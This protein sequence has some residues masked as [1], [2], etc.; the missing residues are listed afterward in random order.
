MQSITYVAVFDIV[1]KIRKMEQN[2]QFF[3]IF[4]EVFRPCP[5]NALVPHLNLLSNERSHEDTQS[6]QVSSS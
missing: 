6:C 1:L 3:G 5:P 4:S 2:N